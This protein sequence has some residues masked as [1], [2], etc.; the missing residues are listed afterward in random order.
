MSK[1]QTDPEELERLRR[2]SF[3]LRTLLDHS[4]DAIYFKDQDGH[5]LRV[6]QALA[7]FF[8][9][10]TRSDVEG[11]TDFDYFPATDAREYKADEQALMNSGGSLIG[12]EE[13]EHGADGQEVWYSTT[14]QPLLDA[15]GKVIGT[16]GISRDITRQKHAEIAAEA[17]SR[18]KSEF[19]ANMSHEIRT[20]MNGI[21][22]AT[23]LL[24]KSELDSHQLEYTNMVNR[25]AD[26][27]LRLLNDI[28][29]FSKIEAGK[30]DL[31]EIPFGLRDS[32]ADSLKLLAA[33]AANKNLELA[34]HISD[35][36]PDALLGDPGRLRQIVMNLAGNAIKFTPEGEIVVGVK[37]HERGEDEVEL[38]FDVTDTGIGIPQ[39]KLGTIFE[40]FGQADSSTTR[41][42][43]GTGLGLTISQRLVEMMGGQIWVESE[44]GR[45]TSFQFTTR[46]G[47][48]RDAESMVLKSPPSLR[49]MKVLV[50]DDNET[51]RRI[52]EEMLR[53]WDLDPVVRG[54]GREALDRLKGCE[55]D[56]RLII[57]DAM[58]PGM[59]GFQAA[60]EIRLVE[61]YEKNSD[62]HADVS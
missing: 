58:M 2:E 16:F 34:F 29:D 1:G 47:I 55:P 41:E 42:F 20:P 19:L 36:V 30:L 61:G 8:G 50:V 60:E 17:A 38:L 6:S 31:E 32:L 53:S 59:D 28:L 18:A 14:K 4:P 37:M 27:L 54:S 26:T 25:S 22:G 43:G 9:E 51:N 35:E 11:K 3:L 33:R 13:P 5:F 44:V 21:I 24:L 23:E 62:H 45:G 49:C 57:L 56:F 10:S 52:L 7:Q 46:L 40:E 12:K 15:D 48:C 39:D